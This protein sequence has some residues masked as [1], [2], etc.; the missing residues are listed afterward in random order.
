M[1]CIWVLYDGHEHYFVLLY[2]LLLIYF[3]FKF[4]FIVDFTFNRLL[5]IPKRFIHFDCISILLHL[6][7]LWIRISCRIHFYSFFIRTVDR[8]WSI[9]EDLNILYKENWTRLAAHEVQ[10]FQVSNSDLLPLEKIHRAHEMHTK[11]FMCLCI[12]SM[13]K[14]KTFLFFLWKTFVSSSCHNSSL[15][16]RVINASF[17][18]L[19]VSLECR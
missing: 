15:Y 10:Q 14:W 5:L 3:R 12:F 6:N 7:S 18:A 2:I 9:T 11:F 8:L 13:T 1:N 16:D 17:Y 19:D 4:I